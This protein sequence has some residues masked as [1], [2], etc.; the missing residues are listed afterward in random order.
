[1]A[2][3]RGEHSACAAWCYSAVAK[4]EP[5]FEALRASWRDLW[6]WLLIDDDAGGPDSAPPASQAL[7]DM[8]SV[9]QIA[10]RLSISETSVRD[11]MD[12]GELHEARLPG[13]KRRLVRRED[14]LAYLGRAR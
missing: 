1:M 12:R 7:P 9:S 3:V 11:L 14:Y 4:K 2:P 10:E 6:R 8:L 13:I 5:D